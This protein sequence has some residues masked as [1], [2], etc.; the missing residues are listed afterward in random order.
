[1]TKRDRST[2][3]G[4]RVE[5]DTALRMFRPNEA[6]TLSSLRLVGTPI[7][8]YPRVLSSLESGK[9]ALLL[10][11]SKTIW[12]DIFAESSAPAIRQMSEDLNL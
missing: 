7:V 11:T 2:L 10:L 12:Y 8:Y 4:Y 1:V 3:W 6:V 5:A 9:H